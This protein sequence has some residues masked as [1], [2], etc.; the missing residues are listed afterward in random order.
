MISTSKWF[1]IRL[2]Y[3]VGFLCI[4]LS[5]SCS[6]LILIPTLVPY[7]VTFDEWDQGWRVSEGGIG[8]YSVAGGNPGGYI[9]G[10]NSAYGVWYFVAS[11]GFV[12]ETRKYYERTLKFDLIQS[13]T[14]SQINAHDVILTDGTT[15]LTF[16]TSYHPNTTWTHY[17]VKLDELSGWKKKNV[18]ATK[19]DMM[20]VLQHLTDLRIRGEYRAGPDQGGLDN[21]IL[22]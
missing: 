13:T 17:S 8:S 15:T 12:R 20:A 4:F 9:V 19:A 3:I 1:V 14:D 7:Y 18:K 2:G 16:N 6:E 10:T 22:Y 5:I 11:K 21:V